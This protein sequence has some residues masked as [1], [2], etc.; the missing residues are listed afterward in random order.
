MDN[1]KIGSRQF[2]SR[3]IVGSG[4]YKSLEETASATNAVALRLLL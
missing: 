1:L 4:K 3:L 2:Q